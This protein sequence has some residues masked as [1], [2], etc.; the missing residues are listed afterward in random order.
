MYKH[1]HINMILKAELRYKKN[2]SVKN[3]RRRFVYCIL[4]K[5]SKAPML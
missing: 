1:L 3:V 5:T 2:I 4:N